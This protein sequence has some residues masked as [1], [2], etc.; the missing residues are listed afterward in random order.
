MQ[1][2]EILLE[3]S[4]PNLYIVDFRQI[5]LAFPQTQNAEGWAGW[6]HRS[7]LAW[8]FFSL[9]ITSN[10]YS[11][12]DSNSFPFGPRTLSPYVLSLAR[13]LPMDQ[14]E[15]AHRLCLDLQGG[16]PAFYL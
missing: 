11:A 3:A 12:D 10:F 8:D 15:C 2:T 14:V 13:L 1:E 7:I 4:L 5:I 9:H 16:T 6:F